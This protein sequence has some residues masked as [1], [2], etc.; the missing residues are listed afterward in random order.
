MTLKH[1]KFQLQGYD[2]QN[3]DFLVFLY[4]F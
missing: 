4:L 3:A 1:R 2:S